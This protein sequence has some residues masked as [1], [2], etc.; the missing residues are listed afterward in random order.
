MENI[1]FAQWSAD[2]HTRT[3]PPDGALVVYK[4]T[5][6]IIPIWVLWTAFKLCY[7][8]QYNCKNPT[9]LGIISEELAGLQ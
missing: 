8:S 1:L 2:C 5:L 4:S 9:Y 7:N 3:V 6:G